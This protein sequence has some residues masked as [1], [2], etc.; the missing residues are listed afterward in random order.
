MK[1]I[2]TYIVNLETSNVRRRYMEDLLHRYTFLDVEF[3]KAFDGR[4]LTPQDRRLV[5]DD[6]SCMKHIGRLLNGGEIGCTLSHRKCCQALLESNE[7]YALILEDDIAPVRDLKEM[8]NYDW[9]K[10]LDTDKPTVLFL[11]GDYWYYKRKAI[12]PV[13]DAVGT[14]SYFINSE[15]AKL[16]LSLGK[17]YNAADDWALYRRNGLKMKAV[18]PYMIDAN[19]NMEVLSSE[20]NQNEWGLNRKK[21]KSS[22]VIWSC[23]GSVVKKIMKRLGLFESKIRVINNVIVNE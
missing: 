1:S 7:P 6:T 9:D 8:E 5:F 19:V 20:I 13:F 18:F 10:W 15:G 4:K 17:P 11:S 22:E 12:V 23:Y 16:I 14:Y 21:M 2:K 3:I